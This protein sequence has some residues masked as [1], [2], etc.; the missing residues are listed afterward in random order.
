MK[1]VAVVILNWNG[2]SFLQK[3][4]PP[5]LLSVKESKGY[6]VS[7]IVADNGSTDGSEEFV[8]TI[9]GVGYIS[10][11]KNWGF[12]GGYNRAFKQIYADYYVLLNSDI[13]T[14]DGWLNPLFNFME[15]HKEAGVCQPK[16][17][18]LTRHL[19]IAEKHNSAE[20]KE[21]FEYA[22][23][24]GG[25][26]DKWGFPF[27]RGR[28]LSSL[29]EDNGQYDDPR[30]IFWASGACMMVRSTL[31]HRL[32]GLDESFFAHMEEID[33]CWRAALMGSQI[34]AVPESYVYHLGGGTL[35]NNSPRKLY[36]NY[37]NNLLMLR[38]NL[39]QPRGGIKLFGR[40]FKLFSIRG[41]RLFI[42]KFLDGLSAVAYIFQGK[43]SY[44]RAV[45]NAHKEYGKIK[46]TIK[47]SPRLDGLR[48]PTGKSF[49]SIYC[50]NGVYPHSIIR[51]FFSG[52][53]KFSD[54]RF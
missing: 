47:P 20:A 24:A 54:L 28:I 3:Y 42:R 10:L 1:K 38:K 43:F 18:S 39:P 11:G 45:W 41:S 52:R 51:K 40:T 48:G 16:M 37:R 32:G 13:L 50:V 4:L 53:K 5:L 12:P 14:P 8:R 22:G 9:G 17:L 7:V 26:I 31:Y 44:C 29:E 33:F 30:K 21:I 6:V 36:L 35:P 23:A 15:A 19:E 49:R 34:W 25:F 46:N 2:K 27:C